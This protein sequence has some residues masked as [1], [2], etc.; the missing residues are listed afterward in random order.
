MVCCLKNEGAAPVKE[1][2]IY[3]HRYIALG[4]HIAYYRKQQ[5]L[6]QEELAEKAGISPGYLSSL[7]SPS[8]P[9]S[10]SLEVLFRLCDHLEIDPALL[11][12]QK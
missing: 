6:T 7:E 1:R 11:F 4:L 10:P 9:V 5:G 8:V 3:Q 2:Q 12:K